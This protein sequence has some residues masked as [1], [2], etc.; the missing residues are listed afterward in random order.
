[1]SRKRSHKRLVAAAPLLGT[2]AASRPEAIKEFLAGRSNG[3]VLLH[4]LYDHVI[5]EPIPERLAGLVED[6]EEDQRRR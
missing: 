6:A 5:E 3:E 2:A 4:G 1:M